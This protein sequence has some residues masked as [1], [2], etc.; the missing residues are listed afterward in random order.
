MTPP[1]TSR[2]PPLSMNRDEA[3]SNA[4]PYE[5]PDSYL[6]TIQSH[7]MLRV[8]HHASAVIHHPPNEVTLR[9]A[10]KYMSSYITA[11]TRLQRPA[12]SRQAKPSVENSCRSL[13]PASTASQYPSRA[14]SVQQANQLV[15]QFLRAQSSMQS[16]VDRYT[17]RAHP[18]ATTINMSALSALNNDK[19]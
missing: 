15:P 4:V 2:T 14:A 5:Y 3:P 12:C 11:D 18:F 16:L 17:C 7:Q 8:L 13:D 10:H 19:V 6:C 1:S 9:V